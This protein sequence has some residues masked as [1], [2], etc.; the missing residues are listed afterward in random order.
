MI[1]RRAPAP[2]AA[3][4][5]TALRRDTRESATGGRVTGY[6]TPGHSAAH[7]LRAGALQV[8]ESRSPGGPADPQAPRSDRGRSTL[9]LAAGGRLSLTL[10]L[11]DAR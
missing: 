8:P 6:Y 10:G 7:S 5:C 11:S 4:A 9:A 2:A 3:C 1:N